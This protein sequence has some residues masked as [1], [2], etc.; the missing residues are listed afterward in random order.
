M[1]KRYAL[2]L[3]RVDVVVQVSPD[4]PVKLPPQQRRVNLVLIPPPICQFRLI[5]HP[6]ERRVEVELVAFIAPDCCHHAG[7]RRGS[8]G[9]GG[10]RGEKEKA[11]CLT[12]AFESLLA[13]MLALTVAKVKGKAVQNLRERGVSVSTGGERPRNRGKRTN[14]L[15]VQIPLAMKGAF[16][17]SCQCCA[18]LEV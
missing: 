14:R 3:A 8:A 2:E 4:D 7:R 1:G 9:A 6:R 18:I 16:P 5:E 10:T 17:A 15:H 12:P 13:F 11:H